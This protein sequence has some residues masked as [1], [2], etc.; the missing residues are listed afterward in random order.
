[1]HQQQRIPRP[2]GIEAG[3]DVEE[4]VSLIRLTAGTFRVEECPVEFHVADVEEFD[5]GESVGPAGADVGR[6]VV[7]GAEEAAQCDVRFVG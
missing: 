6:Y 4:V 5:V 1:M 3:I 7:E 2:S